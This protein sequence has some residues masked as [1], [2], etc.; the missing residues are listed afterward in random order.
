MT[1]KTAAD[2]AGSPTAGFDRMTTG[3]GSPVLHRFGRKRLIFANGN[4]PLTV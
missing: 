2:G 4:N 3:F 1:A